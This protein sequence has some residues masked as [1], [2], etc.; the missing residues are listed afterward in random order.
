MHK[1]RISPVPAAAWRFFSGTCIARGKS[2]RCAFAGSGKLPGDVIGADPGRLSIP[3]A[4]FGSEDASDDGRVEKDPRIPALVAG[5]VF[6]NWVEGHLK[7][8][9]GL[10]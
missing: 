9:L 10:E 7:K 1:V 2:V 8:G 6:D 4:T 3:V 5:E